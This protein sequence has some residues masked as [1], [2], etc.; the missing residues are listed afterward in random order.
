MHYMNVEIGNK[1]LQFPFWEY[2]FQ[3]LGKLWIQ[4]QA[5]AGSGSIRDTDLKTK[6]QSFC[7]KTFWE[8]VG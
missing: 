7:F 2:M 4:V 1:A 3:I 8:N 5:F 6:I